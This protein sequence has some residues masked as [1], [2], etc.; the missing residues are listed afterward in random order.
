MAVERVVA[1]ILEVADVGIDRAAELLVL[2][3]PREEAPF[4]VCR[5]AGE[6]IR[7]EVARDAAALE[8]VQ[9]LVEIP[10]GGDFI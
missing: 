1:L 2:A 7:E 4:G 6:D 5:A 9:R 3:V 8:L 10:H